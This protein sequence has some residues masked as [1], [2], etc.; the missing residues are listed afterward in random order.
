MRKQT[1]LDSWF[2]RRAAS[3]GESQSAGVYARLLEL[4][5]QRNEAFYAPIAMMAEQSDP[6]GWQAL[7][8]SPNALSEGSYVTM[9]DLADTAG[10]ADIEP[11]I[12]ALVEKSHKKRVEQHYQ[13]YARQHATRNTLATAF[14]GPV[15]GAA[16]LVRSAPMLVEA[17][18]QQQ[19]DREWN[20]IY[21]LDLPPRPGQPD[22]YPQRAA[23]AWLAKGAPKLRARKKGMR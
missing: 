20:S 9:M 5:D 23:D 3:L 17:M 14:G 7:L 1:G 4:L 18:R 22:N 2:T 6:A 8:T 10:R 12:R 16:G 15:S 19:M 11:A 21:P 13:A